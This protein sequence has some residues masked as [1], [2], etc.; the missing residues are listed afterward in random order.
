MNTITNS[1]NDSIVEFAKRGIYFFEVL[2]SGVVIPFL[3]LFGISNGNQKKVQDN[4][5]KE[6][7]NTAEISSKPVIG[8]YIPEI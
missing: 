6:I 3:F 7:K 8:F 4:Q 1:T 2:I 5:V